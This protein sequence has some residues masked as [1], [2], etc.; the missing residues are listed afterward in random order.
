MPLTV[1]EIHAAGYRSLRAIRFPVGHLSVFVGANGAG[2]TNLYRALQLLQASAA[3][4]LSHELAGEGGMESALWAGKRKVKEP[5]QI[6]LMVGFAP[7]PSSPGEDNGDALAY[8][9]LVSTGLGGPLAAAFSRESQIKEETLTFH[10]GK[11]PIK[12]LERHG[13]HVVARDEKGLRVDLGMNLMAS[14][15]ALGSLAEPEPFPDLELVRRT[16][17]DWRFYHDLRTDRDSALRRPSLAVTS[18]TLSSDG[19]NLAAVFATLVHIREDD[20]SLQRMIAEAFAGARLVVPEPDRTASFGMIFP[21]YPG[22]VFDAS[23]LSDGTLRYLALAGALMAYRLPSF[24]ALNEPE[25]SLHQDLLDPL[26]RLIVQAS[27]RTQLW[28]VTHSEQL[29]ARLQRHGGI[30]PHTVVKRDGETWIEGLK[31]VG[32]FGDDEE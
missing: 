16:M 23:E 8:S 6:T 20:A 11:R 3:G 2:K 15:T 4:V 10:H 31:L 7:A 22:R 26:A 13:P 17:L 19:S 12:L 14:E 28:L 5:A 24:V 1:R 29:A 32:G 30:K 27:E 18:P 25:T 9:Y 21:E